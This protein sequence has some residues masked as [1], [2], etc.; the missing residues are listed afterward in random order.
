MAI[1]NSISDNGKFRVLVAEDK[2]D[3]PWPKQLRIGTGSQGIAL[4]KDV[5]IWYEL[6]RN[7][8]GFPP[9]YY[10]AKATEKPAKK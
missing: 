5:Q 3:R 9:D 2:D 4:L 10:K 8:N 7:I 6:W 1:E